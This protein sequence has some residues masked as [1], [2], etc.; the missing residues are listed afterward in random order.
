MA[1]ATVTKNAGAALAA[2]VALEEAVPVVLEGTQ[3]EVVEQEWVREEVQ[4][5]AVEQEVVLEGA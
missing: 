3:E 4:G 5:E 1:M 2:K